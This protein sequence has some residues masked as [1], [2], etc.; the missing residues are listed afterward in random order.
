MSAGMQGQCGVYLCVCPHMHMCRQLWA[1]LDPEVVFQDSH[2]LTYW[3]QAV[4]V[5]Q[6]GSASLPGDRAS[7]DSN[8]TLPTAPPGAEPGQ[9]RAGHC[10]LMAA[11]VPHGSWDVRR[12]KGPGLRGPG[13]L[14]PQP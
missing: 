4:L 5:T 12:A 7:A 9:Q 14:A 8:Q 13:M 2:D 3:L 6:P 1:E 11:R 10:A